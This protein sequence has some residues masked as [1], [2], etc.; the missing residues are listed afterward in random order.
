MVVST[1]G[2]LNAPHTDESPALSGRRNGNG[3]PHRSTGIAGGST[4]GIPELHPKKAHTEMVTTAF[5]GE[6]RWDRDLRREVLALIQG[7]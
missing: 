7:A 3:R 4:F 5:R 2:A 1:P 6:L